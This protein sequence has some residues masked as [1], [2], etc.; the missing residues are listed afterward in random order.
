MELALKLYKESGEIRQELLDAQKKYQNKLQQLLKPTEQSINTE[1]IESIILKKKCQNVRITKKDICFLK[2]LLT[3]YSIPFHVAKHEA[4]ALCSSLCIIGKVD[5]VLSEDTDILAYGTPVFL[6]K[7]NT[8]R[9]TC[10]ILELNKL[11]KALSMTKE[12]F[13]DFCIM[14]GTDYNTNVSK[15]GP[16]NSFKLLTEH[17]NIETVIDVLNGKKKDTSVLKH[18][19]CKTIFG[20]NQQKE[21]ESVDADYKNIYSKDFDKFQVFKFKHNLY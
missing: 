20:N 17:K 10:Q 6:Y 2:E 3:I 13:R 8:L 18:E 14:C 19:L 9:E 12:Q 4:E 5:A 16:V 1:L 11:L 7:L 15:V 21:G